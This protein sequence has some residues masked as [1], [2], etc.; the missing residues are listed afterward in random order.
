MEMET[1]SW[2]LVMHVEILNGNSISGSS[3]DISDCLW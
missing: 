2:A 3:F 1:A